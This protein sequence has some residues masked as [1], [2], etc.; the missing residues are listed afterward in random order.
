MQKERPE[1]IAEFMRDPG[2]EAAQQREMP[3]STGFSG[4][5]SSH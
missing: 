4:E 2:G 3:D 5:I 1:G